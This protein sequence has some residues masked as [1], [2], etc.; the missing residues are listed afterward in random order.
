MILHQ[1]EIGGAQDREGFAVLRR[2]GVRC[3]ARVYRGAVV[4]SNR[5]AESD[6]APA[7]TVAR[8]GTALVGAHRCQPPGAA[9]IA[10]SAP[11]VRAA[12]DKEKGDTPL[13]DEM[14]A[15]NK[16]L[17]TLKTQITDGSK[18]Q[19][20]LQL[21]GEMQKH[22]LAAKGMEPARAKKAEERR[23]ALEEAQAQEAQE[24]QAAGAAEPETAE[25]K[26]E[27]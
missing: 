27:E 1:C 23:K 22:F 24:T 8:P 26:K 18:N 19:S 9:A 16:A 5:S 14:I 7:S 3:T 20:S 21:I 2:H 10:I 4:L 11:L 6:V 15:A 13:E 12:D 25:G 17:K